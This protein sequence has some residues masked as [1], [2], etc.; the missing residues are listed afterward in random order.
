MFCGLDL[1][2]VDGLT[3][4]ALRE[5]LAPPVDTRPGLTDSKSRLRQLRSLCLAGAALSDVALR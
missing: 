5:L 3:D 2:Y 4:A 1:G